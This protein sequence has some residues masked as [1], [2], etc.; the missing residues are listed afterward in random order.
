[1]GASIENPSS[2]RVRKLESWVIK[3]HTQI[4]CNVG[5]SLEEYLRQMLEQQA[6]RAQEEFAEKM[7]QRRDE[8][9]AKFGTDFPK[10]DT[11]IQ[12]VREDSCSS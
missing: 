7:Q 4:A 8:I 9:A 12:A 6:L 11:L 1:M 5:M 10:S 3:T 2:I